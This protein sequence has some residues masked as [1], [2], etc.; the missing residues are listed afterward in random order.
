MT[1]EYILL[2]RLEKIRSVI[3]EYGEK[4]FYISFSGGRDSTV[5]HYLIDMALPDNTIPRVFADTG[6]E[7]EAIRDFVKDLAEFDD[8]IVM[9][10][11]SKNIRQMLE[12]EGYPFKSKLHSL[13]VDRF[14]RLGRTKGVVQYL[15]ESEDKKPW[16]SEFS[17]PAMLKYQ[18]SDNFNLRLSQNCCTRLK[19][20][21]LHK[22]A[23]SN[24]KKYAIVGVM[25]DEGGV[26]SNATCE[27]IKNGQLKAFQP[28]AVMSKEWEEWF[29]DQF[30]IPICYVYRNPLNFNRTGC[31][32][33]P[34]NKNLQ[35]E[36]DTLQKFF[37]TE[38]KQCEIIW[39]P[40]Y[41]EYRRIGYRLRGEE[42]GT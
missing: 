26:R 33:C 6:I 31:K 34:F 12:E 17:C 18:F 35:Q 20:D 38:R 5:L 2:D 28:L 32:G 19:K 1:N 42:N 10:K 14:Q 39:K 11:P 37:P 22:W 4:N 9:I 24:K 7:L 21:P 16:C 27:V 25:S 15:G 8:R 3:G 23:R 41:D 13:Y 29:I 30:Q 40:V 36:L